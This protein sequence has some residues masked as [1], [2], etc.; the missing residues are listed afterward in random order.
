M[1][2]TN[3]NYLSPASTLSNPFPGGAIQQPAGP[4][5]GLGTFAGQNLIFM[6]PEMKSP[7]SVRWNLSVQYQLSANTVVEVAYIGN[8]SVHLP[9]TYTQFNG[10]P[11]RYL[12]TAVGRDQA[13]ISQLTA[14]TANP[15]FG[16]QTSN[17]TAGTISVAQLLSRYPEGATSAN[18]AREVPAS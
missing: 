9:V 4:V 12:S 5:A 10:I 2:V 16:L 8:H 17:S 14:T 6:N 7:Y 3:N 15:F 18:A 1:S 13:V 11:R